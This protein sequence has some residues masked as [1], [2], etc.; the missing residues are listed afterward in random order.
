[1]ETSGRDNSSEVFKI[2]VALIA[3]DTEF[4]GRCSHYVPAAEMNEPYVSG[5]PAGNPDVLGLRLV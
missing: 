3:H 5:A 2:K 1:V 4:N